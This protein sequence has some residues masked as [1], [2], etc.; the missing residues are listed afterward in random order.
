MVDFQIGALHVENGE[1]GKG[2]VMLERALEQFTDLEYTCSE[3]IARA[4]HWLARGKL[5]AGG[6]ASLAITHQEEA[7]KIYGKLFGESSVQVAD[8]LGDL[9]SMLSHVER[10]NQ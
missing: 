2:V 5:L 10:Y 1:P 8:A 9:A 4:H 7:V 6:A 3:E